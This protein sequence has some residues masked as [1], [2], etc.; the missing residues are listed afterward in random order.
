MVRRVGGFVKSRYGQH[1]GGIAKKGSFGPIEAGTFIAWVVA[2]L[3]CFGLIALPDLT[4]QTLAVVMV[5]ISSIILLAQKAQI[6]FTAL[7]MVCFAI[8]V[9]LPIMASGVI[10]GFALPTDWMANA[11]SK[12]G[13]W[14]LSAV[15]TVVM[16][17]QD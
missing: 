13:L 8:S 12:I 1:Y 11:W 5:I 7:E 4:Y 10:G 6:K 17:Y 15:G 16:A 2:S 14:S 3:A 9:I